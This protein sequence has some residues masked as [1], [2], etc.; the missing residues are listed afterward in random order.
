MSL[1][2][3]IGF[4]LGGLWFWEIKRLI[5]WFYSHV[6]VNMDFHQNQWHASQEQMST[7]T[8]LMAN[9]NSK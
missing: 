5:D 8:C 1:A 7:K 4:R 2:K 3:S 6:Q 9:K